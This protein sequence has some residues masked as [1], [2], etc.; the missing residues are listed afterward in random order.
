MSKFILFIS[1]LFIFTN[2]YSQDRPKTILWEITQNGSSLKSYLFGTLHDV[3]PDF[4]DSLTNSVAKLKTSDIL[5]VEETNSVR[6]KS[7]ILPNP[8][9]W[10]KSKW[11]SILSKEQ[12]IIFERFILKAERSEF[13]N[14]PPLILSREIAGMYLKDFC[15]LNNS[16]ENL[17]LDG[18]IEKL[19]HEN[20]KQVLSLDENQADLLT[21]TAK[22]VD[23]NLNLDY[24]KGIIN[25]MSK[26]LN[27]DI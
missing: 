27:D 19:A 13:N 7:N 18:K 2:I 24:A 26:M 6:E 5:Y 22:T 8:S 1:S 15:Q 9:I 16:A 17:S 3:N 10:N 23:S 11:A 4:F 21:M 25:L 20:S 14:L 12:A